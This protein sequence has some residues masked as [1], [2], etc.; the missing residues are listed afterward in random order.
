MKG[1]HLIR[2]YFISGLLIWIPI[3]V[4][5]FVIVFLINLLDRSLSLLPAKYQPEQLFG[6]A[7]PGLGLIF[8][9]LVIFITG[10]LI[11]NIVGNRVVNAWEKL[12]ARIPLIR[13]IYSSVKQVSHALLK[14]TDDSFR[15]VVLIEYPRKGVWSIGFQT[16]HDF[17]GVP[18]EE[19]TIAVF[20]P[21]TPNPTSGF[22][23]LVPKEDTIELNMTI[24]EAFKVIISLGVVMPDHNI[25]RKSMI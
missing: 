21:T 12:L 4:T 19:K 15:K 1:K 23:I 17:K 2:R 13:S 11:T 20:I 6:H 7:I 3:G 18:V 8:V 14:P 10:L 24:E 25:S 22:L 16:A 9:I 5:V